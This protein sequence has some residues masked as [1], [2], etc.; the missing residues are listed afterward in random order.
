MAQMLVVFHLLCVLATSVVAVTLFRWKDN[1][2]IIRSLLLKIGILF[3]LAIAALFFP[4][5]G[6]AR[7]QLLAWV[8]FLYF[9]LFLIMGGVLFWKDNQQ[10][11]L[12]LG[13][14]LLVTALVAVDSFLIEPH[15][16]KV[17]RVEIT[18]SKLDDP[19]T[20][21][22]LA[23]IQTDKPGDYEQEVLRIV[24]EENP[25]MILLA[26]D[27][28][29][30]QDPGD[31]QRESG[32]LNQIFQEAS[33][34]APLG[35]FAVRGNIDWENW[36]DIFQGLDIQTFEKTESLDLGPVILTGMS[37]SDSRDP[38][39][40]ISNGDKFQIV[41]G[42]YPDFSLGEIAGDLLLAGHTHGGQIQLPF[43]GPVFINSR[44]PKHW[45]SGLT[46]I[47]PEQYLYVSNGIGLER[48]D[49]PRMRFLCRPEIVFIHLLPAQ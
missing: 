7:I 44:V 27:Y 40:R 16:L 18:T 31:Y 12:T 29:Q 34:T 45:A 49:A 48:G 46:E 43:L 23:D 9:P 17:T 14:I 24:G 3:G 39:S 30:Q 33:L 47:Q 25:D 4:V 6:F 41:L 32:H 15:W 38:T 37:W 13:A 8:A 11:A 22:L 2:S 1:Q 36:P 19:L 10:L 21:A 20:L 42:H 5:P 35:T 26:G 28:I